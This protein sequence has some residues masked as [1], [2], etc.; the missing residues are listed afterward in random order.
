MHLVEGSVTLE[1]AGL[2]QTFQTGATI[3]AERGSHCAWDS[4]EDVAKLF[5]IYRA[6]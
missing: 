1:D 3:L 6:G 2:E 5:A 4:R